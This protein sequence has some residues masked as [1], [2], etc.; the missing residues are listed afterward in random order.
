MIMARPS[1]FH[2]VFEN[3]EGGGWRFLSVSGIV[4]IQRRELLNYGLICAKLSKKDHV[5]IFAKKPNANSEFHRL[6]LIMCQSINPSPSPIHKD[7]F[8]L[9]IKRAIEWK[10]NVVTFTF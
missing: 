3:N 2:R 7:N 4:D 9:K 1:V 6:E 10:L 8:T 5:L